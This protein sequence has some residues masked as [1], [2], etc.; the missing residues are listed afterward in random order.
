MLRDN[1]DFVSTSKGA[2]RQLGVSS[3]SSFTYSVRAALLDN[4]ENA[5][6]ARRTVRRLRTDAL[7]VT[8]SS[9]RWRRRRLEDARCLGSP[10]SCELLP[11]TRHAEARK[12]TARYRE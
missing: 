9:E 7:T 1:R 12:T 2:P 8:L 5:I 4:D 6:E 10:A 11:P 3:P